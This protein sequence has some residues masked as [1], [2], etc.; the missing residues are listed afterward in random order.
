MA[1]G[2]LRR[3]NSHNPKPRNCQTACTNKI[4]ACPPPK[5]ECK[6]VR[7]EIEV[8]QDDSDECEESDQDCEEEC[9]PEQQSKNNCQ[10]NP[11]QSTSACCKPGC[12][13]RMPCLTCTRSGC[14]SVYPGRSDWKR[15]CLTK[16]ELIR[17][18]SEV[19]GKNTNAGGCCKRIPETCGDSVA[20]KKKECHSKKKNACHKGTRKPT[21]VCKI[22]SQ[23]SCNSRDE[24]EDSCEPV[25]EC[26]PEKK[27][28]SPCRKL[29]SCPCS[30]CKNVRFKDNCETSSGF[31]DAQDSCGEDSGR[32]FRSRK[33]QRSKS[34]ATKNRCP[35]EERCKST[36]KESDKKCD[37]A[38]CNQE[39]PPIEFKCFDNQILN[40][41]PLKLPKSFSIPQCQPMPMS[42]SQY[43]NNGWGRNPCSCGSPAC[44]SYA[45]SYG[46]NPRNF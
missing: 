43:P 37:C 24:S 13:K 10:S 34:C 41:L 32:S 44:T 4:N 14:I 28:K 5:P 17:S 38:L 1:G 26:Q 3:L 39:C 18:R 46:M 22:Q 23:E 36:E 20:P 7:I 2:S 25:M 29:K 6:P 8:T 27:S 15:S 35:S 30:D 19:R 11:R 21:D 12:S 42:V 16:K 45:Q 9:E 40:S 33:A 31:G